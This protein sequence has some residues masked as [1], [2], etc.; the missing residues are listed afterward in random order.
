MHRFDEHDGPVRGLDFAKTGQP[1]LASGGD[2][3]K[4]KV[5]NFKQQRC[6]FTLSVGASRGVS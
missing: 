5:F 4:V 3:Y 2:D 6:L 1:L